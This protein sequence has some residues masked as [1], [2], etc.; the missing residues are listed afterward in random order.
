M[1]V[2]ELLPFEGLSARQL[3]DVLRLR[4]DVFVVEQECPYP[5]VD[6]RDLE[7][8]HLLATQEGRLA[9]YCRWYEDA[10]RVVLGRIV[11]SRAVR[12]QGWGR[13]LTREALRRIGAR[14]VRVHAQTRLDG[15]YRALGFTPV[16]LPY[17]DFGVPHVRMDRSLSPIEI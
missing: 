13:A 4:C 10:D 15:F 11:V 7:S 16:G 5:E 14:T 3:H 2:Y 1:L 17:D 9:A 12:G 8:L 6:G